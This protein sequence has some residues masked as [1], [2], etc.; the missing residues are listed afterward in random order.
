L[1][2]RAPKAGPAPA[3][4]PVPREVGIQQRLLAHILSLAGERMVLVGGQ[5]LAFWAAYYAVPQPAATVTKDADFLGTADDVRRIAGGLGGQARFPHD[6]ALT[7]LAG[8][9]T[10]SL[11]GG[12]YVNIDVLH[13]L[14][15]DVSVQAARA[16]AVQ[17]ESEAGRFTVLH[18]LDVLQ[19]RLDNLHG[20]REKQDE[21]GAAQLALAIGITRAFLADEAARVAPEGTRRKHAL[22]LSHLKRIATMARSDAGRKVARRFALHVADG[23]DPSVVADLPAF[24][25]KE[26][27]LLLP[28]LSEAVQAGFAR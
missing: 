20:L 15:G 4:V 27:P 8:Q 22:L 2:T 13:R 25:A 18:P 11:P 3:A 7:A 26:L 10:R 24:R 21:H 5:A 14:H 16:R 17:V 9:V 23:I 6:K 1:S 19:G 28:L 12:D